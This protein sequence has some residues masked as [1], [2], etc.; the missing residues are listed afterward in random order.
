MKTWIKY[1]LLFALLATLAI[2]FHRDSITSPPNHEHAWAQSDYQ[3]L[4]HGFIR[5]NFDLLNAETYVYNHQYPHDW[6][7]AHPSTKTSVNFPIYSYTVAVLMKV[8]GTSE[9]WVYRSFT[10]L[11]SFIGLLYLFKLA[12]ML[13]INLYL[14]LGLVLFLACSPL[15]VFYQANFL[16]GVPAL[17]VSLVGIYHY[18]KYVQT[19]QHKYFLIGIV[20][21]TLS[22]MSRTTYVMPLIAILGVELLRIIQ[23]QSSFWNKVLPTV[24]S[25]SVIVGYLWYDQ[26]YRDIHGSLFL[27]II[28][29]PRSFNEVLEI[30]DLIRERWIFQYFNEQQF[31]IFGGVLGIILFAILLKK[32]QLNDTQKRL[33]QMVLT[34]FLGSFAFFWAMM[35]QFTSHDYYFIDS[36]YLPLILGLTFGVSYIQSA[37]K[38]ITAVA[39]FFFTWIP[40]QLLP[41]TFKVQE[42]KTVE[43]FYDRTR[44]TVRNFTGTKAYF[45]SLGI[46][47][48]DKILVLGAVGPN[49]PFTFFE[50]K[51]YTIF[52][53]ESHRIEKA[54]TWDFDYVVVQNDYFTAEILPYYPQLL[55]LLEPVADNGKITICKRKNT[56][57]PSTLKQF[58]RIP[59]K[60]IQIAEFKYDSDSIIADTNWGNLDSTRCYGI[61]DAEH[62]YGLTYKLKTPK[63][64]NN[65]RYLMRFT[66]KVQS[67]DKFDC[68]V[69]GVIKENGED[70][71]LKTF[72][73]NKWLSV[74]EKWQSIEY[75]FE[76]PKMNFE[77]GELSVFFWNPSKS[78]I[79]YN[80]FRIEIF[81]REDFSV[82]K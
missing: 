8:L 20:F 6:Q 28:L 33:G 27:N 7:V 39:I 66:A 80:D 57:K 23:K 17:S 30:F 64:N 3:A 14:S 10:L 79:K 67:T 69:I 45:D 29:P 62:S 19:K 22:A 40:F 63:F 38:W 46:E 21:L 76:V 54:L 47:K 56:Q 11:M 9:P 15:Y 44:P 81:E 77:K 32:F 61:L 42:Q 78:T 74:S 12:Q 25:L 5:N 48:E 60:A 75:Y 70:K 41:D 55:N 26:W 24:L 34:L 82:L 37:G 68:Y 65:N 35:T 13:N 36:F 1:S 18:F 16:P 31:Q 2:V 43:G 71:I 51:G 4:A 59:E 53:I 73:L 72:N 49:L 52:N 58:K 50:R